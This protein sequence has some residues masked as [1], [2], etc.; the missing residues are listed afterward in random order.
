MN[1]MSRRK[2]LLTAATLPFVLRATVWASENME[3]DSPQTKLANLEKASGGRL[4]LYAINTGNG[5]VIGHRSEERFPMC[6]TFKVILVAAILARSAKNEGFLQRRIH[7]EESDLVTYS[8]ITEKH[9]IGGMTI[10]ELCVAALQ[11]SDNTSANLLMKVV[12]GPAEV[13]AYARSIGNDAFRLDRWETELNTA[14][15]GDPRDTVTP[16]AMA[17][18]LQSLASGDALP[19]A[20][21]KQLNEWLHGSITGAKRIR[22]AVPA[23]WQVGDKTGGGDYGTA[24]DIAVLYPPGHR[25]II[26]AIYYT[27]EKQNTKLNNDIIVDA[28]R[29]VIEDFRPG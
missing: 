6:S 8:P 11:Y 26:L 3:I 23:D 19:Q 1:L 9:I 18:S 10:A 7:Y 27:R 14:I 22:A 4:G 29:I 5:M 13:T 16:A 21:S 20:Q 28:A 12:G 15:P 24:N 17:D 25:P 2:F